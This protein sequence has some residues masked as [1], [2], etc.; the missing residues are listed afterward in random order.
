M[1]RLTWRVWGG[2]ILA[3]LVLL[4]T[5]A[6][7]NGTTGA[8]RE[9]RE[10]I[11]KALPDMKR[12]QLVTIDN[13]A[14]VVA[15][16]EAAIGDPGPVRVMLPIVDANNRVKMHQ[17]TAYHVNL[18]QLDRGLLQPDSNIVAAAEINLLEPSRTFQ[19]LPN[20]DDETFF[21]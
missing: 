13:E 14:E 20:W 8:E 12:Y 15:Q 5:A 16:L 11:A 9:V 6:T 2:L 4:A 18:R 19:G 10:A 21:A 7:C 1:K 3:G 17:W